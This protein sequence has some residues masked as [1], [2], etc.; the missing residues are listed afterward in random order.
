M[1]FTITAFLVA[2]FGVALEELQLHGV[3]IRVER[4][5]LRDDVIDLD[6]VIDGVVVGNEGRHG[7]FGELADH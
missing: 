5:S 1:Q 7:K 2:L 3:A 4:G 6:V